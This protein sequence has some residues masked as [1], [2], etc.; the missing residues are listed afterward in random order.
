MKNL[1]EFKSGLAT[2]CILDINS[3]EEIKGGF[4]FITE[5]VSK[6][7]S[8]LIT[9]IREKKSISWGIHGSKYCVEW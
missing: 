6:F 9:L 8:K 4:R 2:D 7:I 5:D 1:N 3:A